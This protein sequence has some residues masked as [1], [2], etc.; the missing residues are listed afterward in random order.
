MP[1]TII[2]CKSKA[3]SIILFIGKHGSSYANELDRKG[4]SKPH[5]YRTLHRLMEAGI[6]RQ[7]FE[8]GEGRGGLRA[9]YYLT[10]AGE[11]VYRAL[12]MV[13]DALGAVDKGADK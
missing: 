6:L 13:E 10:P 11:K 9:V 3:L 7:K 1:L 8:R 12:L 5:I 4:H 2:D